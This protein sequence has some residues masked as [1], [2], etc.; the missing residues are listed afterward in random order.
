MG[1]RVYKG[2]PTKKARAVLTRRWHLGHHMLSTSYEIHGMYSIL[3]VESHE[4]G[5]ARA[6]DHLIESTEGVLVTIYEVNKDGVKSQSD[7]IFTSTG[8]EPWTCD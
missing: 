4:D 2:T 6:E 7:F 3:S 5:W 1:K 8:L